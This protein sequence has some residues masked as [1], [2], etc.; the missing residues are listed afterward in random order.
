MIEENCLTAIVRMKKDKTKYRYTIFENGKA[1]YQL[2]NAVE[3][4]KKAIRQ[5]WKK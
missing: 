1:Q 5:Q 2:L 4:Y 3:L